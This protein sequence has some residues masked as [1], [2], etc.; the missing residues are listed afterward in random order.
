MPHHHA[1]S[2]PPGKKAGEDAPTCK[3]HV[4]SK[5]RLLELGSGFL[6]LGPDVFGLPLQ[7][8]TGSGKL[9]LQSSDLRELNGM[10]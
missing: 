3:I 6:L 4:N 1:K 10:G 5:P 9:G 8:S 2:S 7:L